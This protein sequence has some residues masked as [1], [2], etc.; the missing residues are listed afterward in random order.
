M[1]LRASREHS[2][3]LTMSTLVDIKHMASKLGLARKIRLLRPPCPVQEV[4]I[5]VGITLP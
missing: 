1:Q 3:R 2:T 4:L 5:C